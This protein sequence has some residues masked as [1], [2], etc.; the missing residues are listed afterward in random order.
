MLQ[1][2]T[3]LEARHCLLH[4]SSWSGVQAQIEHYL[5]DDIPHIGNI[6]K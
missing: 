5:K 1:G 3:A 6:L 2:V 4:K